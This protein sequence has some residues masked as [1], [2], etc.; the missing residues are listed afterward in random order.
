MEPDRL[1]LV[2]WP[3]HNIILPTGPYA[4]HAYSH[5]RHPVSKVWL[6]ALQSRRWQR[7]A[8]TGPG[9]DGKSLM[10]FV[11]PTC[12]A[13]FELGE[14]V[15]VGLPDMR[16]AHDK[17]D[18]DFRPVIEA[19]FPDMMPRRGEGSRGGSVKSGVKFNNGARLRFI[20]AGGG[21]A[22]RAGLTT[23]NLIMTEVDKYDEIRES[24]RESDAVTQ[25]EGRTN[26]FRDFGRMIILEC[27]VSI[28][29]G[30]IWQEIK[31]GSDSHLVH[32]CPHCKGWDQFER[33]HLH[34]WQDANDVIEAMEA[35]Y[36]KCP[37]CDE[38]IN[39][40]QRLEMW[41][42]G[43]LV[44]CGQEI[45]EDGTVVGSEP[46]TDT[47]GFRWTSFVSPF[48]STGV[49]GQL[50]WKAS[51][52]VHREAAEK[53]ARQFFWVIPWEDSDVE[54]TPISADEV[55]RR[56]HDSKK[57]IVPRGSVGVA[58]GID[59]GKRRLH[60]TAAAIMPNESARI[61]DYGEQPV[62]SDRLGTAKALVDA[63]R[64]LCEYYTSGWQDESGQ[65]VEPLQ[66]WIDSGYHEHQS[67]VY[68][69]CKYANLQAGRTWMN[70]IYRPTKGG[71][72]FHKH[73][74]RYRAP[75][76]RDQV[77]RYIGREFHL[78]WQRAAGVMLV[79]VN[80]DYWKSQV[81]QRLR[82]P[83]SEPGAV[84]LY[85]APSPFEHDEFS[86]QITAEKQMEKWVEGRGTAIVWVQERRQNHYLDS[87][88][89][90]LAAGEYLRHE[91]NT[92]KGSGKKPSTGW[93]DAQRKGG[94]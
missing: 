94:R 21:D 52:N 91:E 59:T 44:H 29:T 46:K 8:I 15:F 34:G 2:D 74:N 5:D 79:N 50:E 23:R 38:K 60:W 31:N 6:G 62:E 19:S 4:G 37:N 58:V 72:E 57:G 27:T 64:R 26:A 12:Y 63:L 51:R 17:W 87:T 67:G 78:T 85:E 25:M 69:F 90:A 9:Q 56:M 33:D 75:R 71:S 32:Q 86:Q 48:K 36:W 20:S 14:T 28:K 84:A 18:A 41:K 22:S 45:T 30:R 54:L 13:L 39:N 77:V 3:E 47:F 92:L 65:R 16:M 88:Y 81:H 73:M 83:D 42:N 80:A 61:I 40:D 24:S 11:I 55:Q 89:A 82:M 43:K 70:A 7:Y 49:L 68:E 35:A 1:S 53:E 10:G 93:F 76:E 66:V